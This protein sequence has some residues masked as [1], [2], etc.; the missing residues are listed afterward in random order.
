M[1]ENEKR[2]LKPFDGAPFSAEDMYSHLPYVKDIALCTKE[3]IRLNSGNIIKYYSV[4][5]E[6]S[7]TIDTNELSDHFTQ[8]GHEESA[9]KYIQNLDETE[10]EGITDSAL[11]VANKLVEDNEQTTS[12]SEVTEDYDDQLA[13]P[14][15]EAAGEDEVLTDA[16]AGVDDDDDE[17]D[18]SFLRPKKE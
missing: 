15:G 16:F 7:V 11:D 4:G 12:S 13:A 5:N 18:F 2:Q 17:Y 9:R 1:K 8:L 3:T 10:G 6:E 14:E